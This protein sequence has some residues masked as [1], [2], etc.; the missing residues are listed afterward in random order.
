[1]GKMVLTTEELKLLLPKVRGRYQFDVPLGPT[2]WFQVGG[3]AQVT[4]KPA[5]IQDLCFFL[6]NRP[7]NVPLH[8]IGV[9]SNLLVRDGGV[10]GIV[11]R[12]GSGFTNIYVDET[13]IDVGAAV[14]DRN[15]ASLSAEAGIA[16]F[17]FLCGIP[18]TMGGALRMNAGAYG[19]EISQI[20]TYALVLDPKGKLHRLTPQELGLKYRHSD[21]PSDWIFIGARLK[22]HVGDVKEIEEK[23]S[24]YL[25]EREKTQPVKSRTGG[26]TFANPEAASAWELI[27]KAGC[28][29]LENGE[30][31]M[32]ELHCNFMINRGNATAADLEALGEDVRQ[33]VLAA[34]GVELRWEIERIGSKS[35]VHVGEKAA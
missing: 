18:G 5:D 19:S 16:G 24:S 15:V 13:T 35:V 10:E 9:A 25:A 3:P 20:L 21:L 23:I 8:V 22:G 31:I 27:D 34:T 6:Q 1:M 29:G 30:A 4:F 33:R 28:R 2:T 17:E 26:S 11:V 14:L 12:L 32:S 7:D